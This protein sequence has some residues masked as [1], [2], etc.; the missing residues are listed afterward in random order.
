MLKLCQQEDDRRTLLE[1]FVRFRYK[2]LWALVYIDV[3]FR[4][5]VYP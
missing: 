5:T 1:K 2:Y 4:Y 3:R